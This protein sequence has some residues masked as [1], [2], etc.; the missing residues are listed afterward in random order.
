MPFYW[1]QVGVEFGTHAWYRLGYCQYV[2]LISCLVLDVL[3]LMWCRKMFGG[4]KKLLG[5]KLK[6]HETHANAIKI[7]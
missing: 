5:A 4:A 1:Y 7:D 3:N 6:G 2:L